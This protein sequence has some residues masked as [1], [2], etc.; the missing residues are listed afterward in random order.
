M[1]KKPKPPG[2]KTS[3]EEPPLERRKWAAQV[4]PDMLAAANAALAQK[5]FADPALVLNWPQIAGDATA[6]MCRPLRLSQSAQGGVLTLLA[7]PAAA[8]FLQHETR[9]LCDRINRYFGHPLVAR[10][11]FVQAPLAQRPPPPIPLKP[12][13][14]IAPNDPVRAF[15]GPDAMREALCRLARARHNRRI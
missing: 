9:S 5:G 8:L 2:S 11:R 1:A 14:E 6:R 12:A 10:L 7:E 13:A 15:V 3:S 4:A